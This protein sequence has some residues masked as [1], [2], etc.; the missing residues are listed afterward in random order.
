M[1]S[2]NHRIQQLAYQVDRKILHTQ[3]ED[4]IRL[5]IPAHEHVSLGLLSQ[6]MPAASAQAAALP[7]M[8]LPQMPQLPQLS[9]P[10]LA[11]PS[12]SVALPKLPLADAKRFALAA[13]GIYL[14]LFM[15]TNAGAYSKIMLASVQQVWE[16]H[17]LEQEASLTAASLSNLEANPWQE[18][19]A[20]EHV[21][22]EL[23][24]EI[25]A[26]E[27]SPNTAFLSLNELN[28]APVAPDNRLRIPAINVNAPLVE[29]QLALEALKNSDWNALENQIQDSLLEGVVYYPGTAKP[30]EEGNMVL[31]GHSSNVFW[32]ISDYNTV[33][34]LL[35]R[36]NVGEDIFITYN[37]Q[38]FHYR[39]T[40]K[41]EIKPNEVSVLEQGKGKKLTA[42]TCTPVGTRLKRLVVQAELIEN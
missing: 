31:T 27:S 33:F 2:L 26:S 10:K 20:F 1:T 23:P 40:E 11:A 6:P 29:P 37:Q 35:P 32:E 12:L 34:A 13:L 19:R 22:Q 42:I 36:L 5:D 8:A 4:Y 17:Q 16:T 24:L 28:L 18:A 3:E 15:F 41:Y 25:L 39:V 21:P 38:E 30:G 7:R 14:A 9:R